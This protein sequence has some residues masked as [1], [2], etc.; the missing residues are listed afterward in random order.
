M[1]FLGLLGILD[2]LKVIFLNSYTLVL[3]VG[4]FLGWNLPQPERAKK[5]QDWFVA[6]GKYLW[7]KIKNRQ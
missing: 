5:V 2:V 3:A 7:N 1:D 6:T 4:L